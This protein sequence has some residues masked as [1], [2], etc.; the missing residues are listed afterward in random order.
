M[1]VN[2]ADFERSGVLKKKGE[3]FVTAYFAKY[4]EDMLISTG[5]G[6]TARAGI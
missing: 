6:Q 5:S 4:Q 3:D 2:S 1:D